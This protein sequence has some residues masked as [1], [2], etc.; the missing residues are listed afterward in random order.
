[1]I[2]VRDLQ[3]SDFKDLVECYSS[4]QEE[5][6][7]NPALGIPSFSMEPSMHRDLHWFSGLCKKVAEGNAVVVVGEADSHVVGHCEVDRILHSP[8]MS[9]Q[10]IL[11]MA[12]RKE[13]R[14]RG[15]GTAMLELA[16]QKCEG[17]FETLE[18]S[19]FSTNDGAKRL[20]E[21]FRFKSIGVKPRAIKR[22]GA[23]IDEEIMVLIL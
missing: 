4:Y 18:L 8:E 23:Y 9:H 15:V 22:N 16:L 7:E 17:K 14:G 2:V 10:G 19:V 21:R 12:V 3:P 11:G 20:Y 6:K 5:L 1:M 13:H